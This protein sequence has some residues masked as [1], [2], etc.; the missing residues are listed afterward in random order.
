MPATF[1]PSSDL[2][3]CS[4]HLSIH[5]QF[6]TMTVTAI[7]T[8]SADSVLTPNVVDL[9][10]LLN[11]LDLLRLVDLCDLLALL[12]LPALLA[13]FVLTLFARLR[14]SQHR[15]VVRKGIE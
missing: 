7:V 10:D 11:F 13:F 6:A 14:E 3:D 2:V 1:S 8:F 9:L 4:C 12:A 15:C 5:E